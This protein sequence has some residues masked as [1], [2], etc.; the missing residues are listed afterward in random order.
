MYNILVK[1]VIYS[2]WENRLKKSGVDTSDF[3]K[4]VD[5]IE[6]KSITRYAYLAS[7]VVKWS[8]TS[9]AVNVETLNKLYIT[10]ILI[11][12]EVFRLITTIEINLKAAIAAEFNDKLFLRTSDVLTWINTTL[13][14]SSLFL[15][16][17]KDDSAKALKNMNE[18]VNCKSVTYNKKFD[19][20]IDKCDISDVANLLYVLRYIPSINLSKWYD[21][22]IS[23]DSLAVDSIMIVNIR[24]AVMHHNVCMHVQKNRNKQPGELLEIFFN[25]VIGLFGEKSEAISSIKVHWY[26]IYNNPRYDLKSIANVIDYIYSPLPH[27]SNNFKPLFNL[28]SIGNDHMLTKK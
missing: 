20:F 10:D 22:N 18:L 26:E 6:K 5:K 16:L 21:G 8:K 28:N 15:T 4:F 2:D 11:R 7:Q 24:N 13:L 12:R 3:Y 17:G 19:Q 1:K 9:D 14:T 25:F 23:A 27:Q